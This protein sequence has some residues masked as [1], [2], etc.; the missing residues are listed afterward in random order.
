MKCLVI[1]LSTLLLVCVAAGPAL[2]DA[3]TAVTGGGTG[4]FDL[5]HPGS[6]FGLGVVFR[7]GAAR[8]EFN[9]VMAGRSATDDLNQ[10]TVRGQVDGGSANAAA[11]TAVFSGNGTVQMDGKRY[12]ARFTVTVLHDGGPGVGRFQLTVVGAAPVGVL[13]LPP[14]TV[15]TGRIDVH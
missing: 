3:P 15:A 13:A 10:M 11:G 8:G 6:Q 7:G 1:A 12:P 9:C 4:T 2:A 5:E 14:E